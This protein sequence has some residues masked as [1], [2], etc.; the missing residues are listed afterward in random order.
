MTRPTRSL[1]FFATFTVAAFVL[2]PTLPD[3]AIWTLAALGLAVL[4]VALLAGKSFFL[5]RS[6]MRAG[7]WDD[8]F[9]AFQTFHD[10]QLGRGW[11]A[12]LSFLFA[13]IYTA[14]GV[15]LALNNQ[16]AVRLNQRQLDEAEALFRKAL[17]R[18]RQY[19]MPH[20]NLAIVAAMRGDAATAEAE[21]TRAREL[22]FRRR[23]LQQ[24]VRAA[25]AAT[26]GALG[27]SLE[28]H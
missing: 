1:V 2:A 28:H 23:G 21:S 3:V 5:G 13:G 24:A 26:N 4:M 6:A 16:G 27:S 25:L 18:D 20:V 11:Q 9:Q 12:R 7:R 10:Q 17:A 8:A 22:G 14:D 15:A 19:A